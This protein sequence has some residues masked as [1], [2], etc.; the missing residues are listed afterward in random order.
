MDVDVDGLELDLLVEGCARRY[1]HDLRSWRRERLEAAVRKRGP[2]AQVLSD[3]L[4]DG[5]AFA[6]L[7]SDVLGSPA[8]VVDEDGAR[9]LAELVVPVLRTWPFVRVWYAGRGD[10]RDA[11]A[12]W[13]VLAAHGLAE[14]TRMFATDVEEQP[15]AGYVTR[16]RHVPLTDRG[17]GEFNLVVCRHLLSAVDPGAHDALCGAL[18]ESVVRFGLLWLD[19]GRSLRRTPLAGTYETLDLRLGLHRR[20]G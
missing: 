11:A 16:P 6:G 3:V 18:H 17:F 1:G 12:L 9:A 14:R 5:H 8:P 4:R 15:P 20:V 10:G 7:L 2:T 13:N 19:A